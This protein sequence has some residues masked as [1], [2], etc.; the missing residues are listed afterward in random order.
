[1]TRP[2]CKLTPEALER[3]RERDRIR[4]KKR[5]EQRKLAK[6][7][8][9]QELTGVAKRRMMPIM[10]EMTK[11]ELREMLAEAVRNTK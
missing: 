5:S 10:P 4:S 7:I 9:A 2:G 8:K 11:A 3:R 6:Q 1:M